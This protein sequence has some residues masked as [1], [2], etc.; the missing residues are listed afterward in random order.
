MKATATWFCVLLLCLIMGG[1]ISVKNLTAEREQAF[2][3]Y[4]QGNFEKASQQFEI[5]VQE[6][7]KDAELWFK[8]GNSYARVQYPQKAIEA[9]QNALLR[10]PGLSKAWYNMGII[11]MQTALKTFIDMEKYTEAAD[12]VH[13][14]G[15]KM[16]EGLLLLLDRSDGQLQRKE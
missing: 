12:P 15:K 7:P 8:L 13:L 1:C 4:E 11:Q 10:D 2:L 3:A 5:L 9:Y 6:I 14:K 16:R